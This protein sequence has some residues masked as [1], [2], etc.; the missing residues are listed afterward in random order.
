MVLLNKEE[1]KQIDIKELYKT[2]SSANFSKSLMVINIRGTNG[3]GKSTVPL[4]MMNSDE[5]T[6]VG[7]WPV[8]TKRGIKQKPYFTVFPKYNCLA[9]GTYFNKTGGLDTYPTNAITRKALESVWYSPYHIIMEGIIASTI[10]STYASL[11]HELNDIETLQ[12]TIVIPSL[13]PPVETCI[14]RV[15]IRNGGKP[16]KTD[17]IEFKWSVVDKNI[18]YFEEEGFCSF[19]LDNSEVAIDETLDWFNYNIRKQTGW[20]LY[21]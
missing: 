9:L 16:V 4:L 10:K 20:Y 11:F 5:N 12:R 17:Q 8:E 18:S 14:N 15:L 19:P 7:T 13:V 21:N 3:S 1:V 6:F 2:W